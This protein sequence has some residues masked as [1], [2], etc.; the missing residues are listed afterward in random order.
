MSTDQ[1]Q[2]ENENTPVEAG[3]QGA[4]LSSESTELHDSA[5]GNVEG[6]VASTDG[7]TAETAETTEDVPQL[8]LGSGAESDESA[9]IEEKEYVQPTIRGRIDKFGTAIGTGRRKTSVARVRVKDGNGKFTVNGREMKDFF[10]IER[11]QK[12]VMDPVVAVGEQGKID[13]WVR[14]NGG[15]ITGQTGAVVLGIARALQ[16]KNES[17]HPT[18]AE[19]GFLTRDDRMVERKKYGLAKARKSFQFSK[20]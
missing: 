20:R 19:G 16:A 15:G 9:D 3:D 2:E 10:C 7:E 6:V 11:D 8:T 14:V 1:P 5:E 13:I 4:P 18:L 12:M 17:Y